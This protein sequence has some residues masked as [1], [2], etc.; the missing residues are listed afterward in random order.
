M[1]FVKQT[2]AASAILA[3]IF[4]F[5]ASQAAFAASKS[6]HEEAVF[7]DFEAEFS[8]NIAA[9]QKEIEQ[10]IENQRKMIAKMMDDSKKNLQNLNSSKT[11]LTMQQ[12]KDSYIYKVTFDAFKKEDVAVSVNDRIMTISAKSESA[13]KGKISS[14]SMFY[15]LSIPQDA[16]D[17]PE[18]TRRKNEILIKFLKN[19]K[20][21]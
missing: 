3:L 2:F 4:T 12:E 9:T 7:S 11:S 1:K 18:L 5:N 20:S 13:K 21:D 16:S 17:V 19:K 8:K 6:S 10:M 15:S 14:N